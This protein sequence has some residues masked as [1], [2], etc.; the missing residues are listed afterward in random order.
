MEMQFSREQDYLE[1]LRCLQ[2]Q[3]KDAICLNDMFEAASRL[4]F[5][6]TEWVEFVKAFHKR[7]EPNTFA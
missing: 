3:K 4:S 1:L 2:I 7:S 5:N 6:S